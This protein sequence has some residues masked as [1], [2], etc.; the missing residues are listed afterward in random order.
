[1]VH[2]HLCFQKDARLLYSEHPQ[3]FWGTQPPLPHSITSIIHLP[4]SK[5]KSH[6]DFR[7]PSGEGRTIIIFNQY[8]QSDHSEHKIDLQS[9]YSSSFSYIAFILVF[10]YFIV[11]LYLLHVYTCIYVWVCTCHSMWALWSQETGGVGF[12]LPLHWSWGS[13]SGH[14]T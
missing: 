6:Q 4:I 9:P 8:L 2:A 14:H 12:L 1:M 7:E 3:H 13:N 11:F 10:L 5:E